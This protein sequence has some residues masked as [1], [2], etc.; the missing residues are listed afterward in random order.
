VAATLGS[1]TPG[2][3][4]VAAAGEVSR[5]PGL[6]WQP[7]CPL[8]RPPRSVPGPTGPNDRDGGPAPR[9]TGGDPRHGRRRGRR[10][11]GLPRSHED[12][13][14]AVTLIG[15]LPVAGRAATQFSR[16]ERPSLPGRRCCARR[17]ASAS[18]TS[19]SSAWMAAT[20][21]SPK[22]ATATRQQDRYVAAVLSLNDGA[23]VSTSSV[24]VETDVAGRDGPVEAAATRSSMVSPTASASANRT[25]ARMR[26]PS[27]ELPRQV[28]HQRV[29]DV[30]RR[31]HRDVPLG[32]TDCHQHRPN[33]RVTR[34][35]RPRRRVKRLRRS[36][37]TAA[38]S[39]SRTTRAP[40]RVTAPRRPQTLSHRHAP[41]GTITRR[42]AS[43]PQ[44]SAH[45]LE[46]PPKGRPPNHPLWAMRWCG[47]LV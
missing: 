3:S 26:R 39:P 22:R 15:D 23:T 11:G 20:G 13:S 35:A 30:H 31:D 38:P 17:T 32:A 2:L 27:G 37:C 7:L 28:P 16:D 40:S 1:S 25:R 9:P 6:P 21:S 4:S 5:P 19:Q 46:P 24:R 8:W 34:R 41:D 36:G 47:D 14:N 42:V 18:T 45:H 33:P 43:T 10:P 44:P 29:E 12:V